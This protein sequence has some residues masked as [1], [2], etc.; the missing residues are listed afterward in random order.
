MTLRALVGGLALA[1]GTAFSVGC[2]AAADLPPGLPPPPPLAPI[3]YAP[4]VYNWT[5]IYF[6]GHL[7]AGYAGSSWSDHIT[8]GSDNFSSWGF[9][10]GAQ[11]GGNIQFDRLVLG[12][13]GDFGRELGLDNDFAAKVIKSVGN[14]GEIFERN[15][16]PNT[17][18]KIA[19]GLNNL[20]TK[21]GIQY[22]PPVR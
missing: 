18:L 13:E 14:Y 9:L 1:A 7:G 20:W 19:R 3:A 16:G 17:P 10:G 5:G 8:G 15:V 6:G 2:A 4:P 21:G 11:V 22:A 12:V